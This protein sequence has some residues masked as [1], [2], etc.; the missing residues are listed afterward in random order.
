VL[1]IKCMCWCF[2]HYCIV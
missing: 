2:V 1:N